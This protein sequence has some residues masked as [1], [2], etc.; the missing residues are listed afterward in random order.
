[1]AGPDILVQ[2]YTFRRVCSN[3]AIAAHALEARR[4]ERVEA[5]EVFVPAYEV[6]TALAAVRTAARE[7]AAPKAFE[8]VVGELRSAAEAEADVALHLLPMLAR[9]P[10]EVASR[11]LPQI[12]GRF[13]AE[14][15]RTVFALLN[16]VTSVGRDTRDPE[17]R[18]RLEELGGTM[19]ARLTPKPGVAP[20]AA[21]ASA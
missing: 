18:W 12:L 10:A 7:C 2:P 3:G 16:A 4:I 21:L 1:V 11:V 5:V 9:L 14:R 20:A 19:P 8:T 6:A 13:A 17:V 15:D